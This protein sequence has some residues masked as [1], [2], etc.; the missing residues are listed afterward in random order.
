MNSK[1]FL[2]TTAAVCMWLATIGAS[3]TTEIEL[4]GMY[5]WVLVCDIDNTGGGEYKRQQTISSKTKVTKSATVEAL[6]RKVSGS[7]S[8]FNSKMSAGGTLKTL[9]VSSSGEQGYSSHEELIN[10]MISTESNNYEFEKTETLQ[11][12]ITVGPGAKFVLYQ[13]QF[14]APGVF[15]T[16]PVTATHPK[17]VKVLLT[18]SV[19]VS[20]P[21]K[22]GILPDG[23]TFALK[24]RGGTY[25]SAVK[26]GE[27]LSFFPSLLSCSGRKCKQNKP[28]TPVLMVNHIKAWEKFTFVH[29]R[30]DVY[31]IRSV[32][33]TYL[34]AHDNEKTVDLQTD[35]HNWDKMTWEQWT[36]VRAKDGKF[37]F[38][39]VHG[40]YLRTHAD[41][42]V[43]LSVDKHNW[44]VLLWE[45][46]ELVPVT[47]G[48]NEL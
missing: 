1:I 31:G 23:S 8:E 10:Q 48:K 9:S 34:R 24:S 41:K 20:E 12:T 42:W 36:V 33:G 45:Q 32:H 46:F 19:E 27:N 14:T 43:G 22:Q 40:T 47:I 3:T 37:A 2:L 6:K 5:K 7:K 35:K 25:L 26:G 30:D 38:R 17:E 29:V 13:L 4:P 39:S 28:Q 15:Q 16:F 44:D 11:E 21:T 18:F